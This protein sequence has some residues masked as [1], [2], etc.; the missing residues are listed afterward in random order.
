MNFEYTIKSRKLKQDITFTRPGSDYIY[1]DMN[2][3][4]GTLGLQICSG[5]YLAGSTVGYSGDDVD[6]FKKV[7]RNWW[8]KYIRNH[9]F[10]LSGE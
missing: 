3:Q 4:P 9:Y 7:C 5:G 2:G 6:A 8:Q 1:V 10:D